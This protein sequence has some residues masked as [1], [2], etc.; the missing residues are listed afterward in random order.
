MDQF[1]LQRQNVTYN[2]T[3]EIN[4]LPSFEPFLTALAFDFDSGSSPTTKN[5]RARTFQQQKKMGLK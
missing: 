1:S 3:G 2:I 4:Q 5:F